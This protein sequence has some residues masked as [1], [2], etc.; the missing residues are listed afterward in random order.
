MKLWEL[1]SMLQ[2]VKPFE[3][4]N[5]KWEQYLTTPHLASHMIYN[6]A[7]QGDVEDKV[8]LDLGTGTGMLAVASALCGASQVIGIDLDLDALVIAQQNAIECEVDGT[9]D[10]INANVF[11]LK[12]MGDRIANMVD[13]VVLN[14]PF[15]TRLKGADMQFLSIAAR[16]ANTA[17]YSLH[18][19]ST[20]DYVVRTAES[21]GCKVTVLAE[22]A[23]D[24][25]ATYSFHKK[26]NQVIEVDLIRLE[27]LKGRFNPEGTLAG[28]A[29]TSSKKSTTNK[30]VIKKTNPIDRT[31][32]K[33]SN[34]NK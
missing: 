14:P 9:I 32:K 19:T 18:K 3:N 26:Q 8:V 22:M 2:R 20:I 11:D 13:T 27:K 21:W 28:K 34:R 25:P 10:L 30:P 7:I 12:A 16:V 1:E 33:A 31:V 17:V 23:Y 6:A 29:K 5:I 4:P 24:L 15:G